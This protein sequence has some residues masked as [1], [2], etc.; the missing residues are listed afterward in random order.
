MKRHIEEMVIKFRDEVVQVAL[1]QKWQSHSIV[2][3]MKWK[4]KSDASVPMAE[5]DVGMLERGE[6]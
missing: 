6:S 4:R 5:M 2:G 3:M 1:E